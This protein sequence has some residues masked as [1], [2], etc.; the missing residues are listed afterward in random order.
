MLLLAVDA[1]FR[2]KNRMKANE[3]DNPPL[4][5]GWGYWVEPIKYREHSKNYIHKKDVSQVVW[6][7]GLTDGFQ[8]RS[9][10]ASHSLRSFRRIHN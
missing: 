10:L 4:G 2:L 6:V 3:I 1:N 7:R 5:P 8:C 9:A